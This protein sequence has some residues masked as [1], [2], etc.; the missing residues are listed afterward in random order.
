MDVQKKQSLDRFHPRTLALWATIAA[1]GSMSPA[2]AKTS[3]FLTDATSNFLPTDELEVSPVASET[4]VIVSSAVETSL[5]T[6]IQTASPVQTTEVATREMSV[7]ADAVVVPVTEVIDA[8]PLAE[9]VVTAASPTAIAQTVTPQPEEL[10]EN[11]GAEASIELAS[12]DVVT[13]TDADDEALEIAVLAPE[14][15]SEDPIAAERFADV[16]QLIAQEGAADEV[17]VLVAEI[18]INGTG[19]NVELE[20][21]VVQAIETRAGLPTTVT[22]IRNDV[23]RI[24]AT[25]L[26]A[27]VVATP[28]DTP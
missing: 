3:S 2:Q 21:E 13:V 20:Q 24:Y 9:T 28:E 22:Q 10:A 6:A 14:K 7:E 15:L 25:G 4:D 27:N 23:N 16:N 12:T 26:F 11:E 1:L 19:G 8:E 17:R 5:A 18:Q